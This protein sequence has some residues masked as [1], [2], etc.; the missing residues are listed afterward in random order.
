MSTYISTSR[1]NFILQF[2]IAW[3][4]PWWV[5]PEN[6][7]KRWNWRI[8]TCYAAVRV[9]TR[10][11]LVLCL[12][13]KA[14]A[15]NE[16]SFS[17]RGLLGGPTFHTQLSSYNLA[18]KCPININLFLFESLWW[19]LSFGTLFMTIRQKTASLYFFSHIGANHSSSLYR[20]QKVMWAKSD[21]VD[22]PG[23]THKT[24]KVRQSDSRTSMA[25]AES[26]ISTTNR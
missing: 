6:A 19:D 21:V 10:G 3:E 14:S 24:Q 17:S 2:E 26:K 5:V 13:G 12:L 23:T 20:A 9:C 15:P 7:I 8:R 1:N 25:N 11:K 18:G 22:F 4:P 16:S